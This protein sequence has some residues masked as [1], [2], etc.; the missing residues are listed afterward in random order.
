MSEAENA[1]LSDVIRDLLLAMVTS[2]NEANNAF[3]EG[4]KELTEKEIT[5]GYT[6]TIDGKNQRCEIKGSAL[7]FGVVPTLLSI[8]RSTI[9]IRVAIAPTNTNQNLKNRSAYLFKTNF[10]DAKYQNAYSY[11]PETSSNIKITVVPT[12]PSAELLEA[13]KAAASHPKIVEKIE[14]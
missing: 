12:P 11:K 1:T 6:K 2:Q 8:Q 9:E 10:V 14:K 4:I 13:V 7:A 5:L 3:I